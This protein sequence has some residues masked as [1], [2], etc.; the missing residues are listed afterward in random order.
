MTI[1][2]SKK[3]CLPEQSSNVKKLLAEGYLKLEHNRITRK[4]LRKVSGNLF[5]FFPE[6]S[7]EMM[8]KAMLMYIGIILSST[9]SFAVL[10]IANPS[11]FTFFSAL[12]ISYVMAIELSTG[13]L[14]RAESAFLKFMDEF[15]ANVKHYYCSTGCVDEAVYEAA[16]QA[17]KAFRGHVLL[18][19][20]VLISED[21]DSAQRRYLSAGKHKYLRL[22]LS[23]AQTIGENGDT[24]DENGSVFLNAIMQLRSDV[25][26]EKRFIDERRHRFAGLSLTAAL[27]IIAVPFIAGWATQTIPSLSLFYYGRCG[28]LIKALLLVI[29]YS[30]YSA[31]IKLREGDRVM[32]RT[33]PLASAISQIKPI[34]AVCGA[35]FERNYGKSRTKRELLKKLNETY[36]LKAFYVHRIIIA[37][38]AALIVMCVIVFGHFE[39]QGILLN[40]T[41]DLEN[42][43]D[44][45]DGKQLKAME[46]VIPVYSHLYI[47][48]NSMPEKSIIEELLLQEEGIST[49]E[50]AEAAAAEIIRRTDEYAKERFSVTDVLITMAFAFVIWLY[51]EVSL[52]F[53]KSLTEN[54]MQDEV[55]QFQSLI[56][57]QKKVP[58]MNP[59]MILESMEAFAQIFKPSVRQCINEYNISD[60]DALERMYHNEKY[61]AFRRIVD[62]FMAVDEAG[63]EEAFD[64]IS[65]EIINFKES[66][67]LDRSILLDNENMLASLISV[68]PGG[69][70]L[71]GYLLIPFMLKSLMMF[72]TYQD[73]LKQLID[74]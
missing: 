50:V 61:P 17:D 20:E 41:D 35:F 36:S 1:G 21:S 33:Y 72:D 37:A 59:V 22:F 7:R 30:C 48:G 42:I 67:K 68:L 58:G 47:A 3:G 31:V 55:I 4:V 63:V 73:T 27:P 62:C 13:M 56:H 74:S 60:T 9:A 40:N 24:T 38:G 66:R 18:L 19:Y 28:S 2:K 71:F 64:E 57:M 6:D 69:I 49:P 52:Q 43:C 12:L 26:E 8:I 23:I 54:R 25:R 14:Y 11:V 53:R 70:I 45:A 44:V 15:L 29:T 46:R 34:S 10:F 16:S 39:A 5:V 65:S 51:P 32:K